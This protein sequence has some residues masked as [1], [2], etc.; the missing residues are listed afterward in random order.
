MKKYLTLVMLFSIFYGYSQKGTF[1]PDKPASTEN[2]P[3][4]KSKPT[5]QEGNSIGK[6]ETW[7]VDAQTA[8]CNN[9]P[10]TF[11]LRI[12][13]PGSQDFEVLE[14]DILNFNYDIGFTYT[15]QVKVIAGSKPKY[16]CVK[17]LSKIEYTGEEAAPAQNTNTYTSTSKNGKIIGQ[18]S[19]NT[20]SPLD[21]KWY[22]RKFKDTNGISLV[23]DANVM[24][25]E[26]NTFKDY[27]NGFGACNNFEA[28]VKSDQS[29][30]FQIIKLTPNT[31]T[32]CGNKTVEDNFL[33]D[34]QEADRF[35]IR[36]GN[37]VLTKQWHFLMQFTSDPNNKEDITETYTPPTIVKNET[38]TYATDANLTTRDN[39]ENKSTTSTGNISEPVQPSSPSATPV[40]NSET[41]SMQ[42]LIASLQKQLAEKKQLTDQNKINTQST[43]QQENTVQTIAENDIKKREKNPSNSSIYND[44]A[45]NISINK[46]TS[47]TDSLKNTIAQPEKK[48]QYGKQQKIDE[49]LN[50]TLTIST[51]NNQNNT[52]DIS[53]INIEEPD[54]LYD[55]YYIDKYNHSMRIERQIIPESIEK[56]NSIEAEGT[57]SSYKIPP[58][59]RLNFIVKM[60][61]NTLDPFSIIQVLKMDNHNNKRMV[62]ISKENEIKFTAI[63]YKNSSFIITILSKLS[64]GE[65]CIN[66]TYPYVRTISLFSINTK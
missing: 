14:E 28:V 56:N 47:E 36:D 52:L 54:F 18:T 39:T 33:N 45:K 35:E 65:Y 24:Y 57:K 50:N 37:L 25:I 59:D 31:Y 32:N 41:D 34:L 13:R 51:N 7:T 30:T 53:A 62:L 20:S 9:T 3:A 16:I 55:I 22:L 60:E 27:L 17:T 61:N 66:I 23:T 2:K 43:N 42:R 44:N 29:T 26:I 40:A 46:N 48:I 12:K 8:P 49:S 38:A 4:Y 64:P 5:H 21:K 10:G 11:C 1:I 6:L 58:N 15:I 19:L 63:K